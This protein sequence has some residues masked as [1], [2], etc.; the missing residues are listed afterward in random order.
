MRILV[1]GASGFIGRNLVPELVALGY[2]VIAATRSQ[3][4]FEGATSVRLPELGPEADFSCCL[5]GVDAV[6]HLAGRAHVLRESTNPDL[7]RLYLKINCEG[8]RALAA[9]SASHG[10]KHMVF[11]SSCHAVSAA[12]ETRLTEKT[13]PAPGSTYGRSK[14]AAEMALKSEL[15]HTPCVYTILR[16]PLVYGPGNLANFARLIKLV[17]SGIPL[18]FAAVSNRR[19]FLS[20]RN[21]THVITHCL[22]NKPAAGRTYYP[23]DGTDVS[24][25]ELII[26]LAQAFGLHARLVPF[27]V[28]LL[29]SLSHLPGMGP[30]RKLMSSL[31]VDSGPLA[32]DLGW[33]PPQTLNEG[34]RS[35][36]EAPIRPPHH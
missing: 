17:R 19:S 5:K 20:V 4:T 31:F 36:G 8:T 27:P 35:I 33:I 28:P 32:R 16:P 14:L 2:D 11:L 29:G 30:L 18:P 22:W 15:D 3:E 23:S 34:L 21:L 9:Q 7:E 26:A 13:E 12:S 6:I 1:T 24:T 10:V 25:P